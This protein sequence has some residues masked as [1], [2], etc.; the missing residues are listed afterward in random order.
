VQPHLKTKQ[1]AIIGKAPEFS[2]PAYVIY[3]TEHNKD[4]FRNAL[5]VMHGI[6]TSLLNP[7]AAY[8]AQEKTC[9]F[10]GGRLV[11]CFGPRKPPM[12]PPLASGLGI[13][14]RFHR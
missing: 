12:N 10:T 2:I 11:S 7:K 13:S 5:E 4:T 9:P 1:L 8:Q 14:L 3:P 6:A